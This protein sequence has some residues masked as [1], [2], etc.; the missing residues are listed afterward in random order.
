MYINYRKNYR[1]GISRWAFLFFACC[2]LISCN[3]K[4][5]LKDNQSFL[6][7]NKIT[8]KSKSKI[9]DK[10]DLT[11]NLSHLYRQNQTKTVVGIPRH[12]FYY[13]YQESLLKNPGRKQWSEERLIKNRPVI[14]DSTK[15]AQTVVDFEKYLTL[16]G[17]RYARASFK[18]KTQDK[19][20]SVYYRVDPGPRTYVD[21]F[22]I[23]STD[24]ALIRL[25]QNNQKNS[26][27]TRGSPLDI[28]LYN[29][30]RSRL[31][32]LFQN[33]GY[34]TFDETS[35]SPLEADTNAIR[36]KATLRV[37]N[38]TDSTFHQKYYVGKVT[39]F[40]DYHLTDTI[41]HDTVIRNVKY[42]T[43]HKTLTLKPEVMERNIYVKQGDLTRKINLTQTSRNLGKIELLRFVTPTTEIDTIS[44]DTP[45]VNY[46][47]FLSR[48]K[49][50]PLLLSTELTY[51]NIAGQK[52]S[53]LGASFSANYRDLNTF[54]GAEVLNLNFETGVEFY[55]QA[56]VLN[57]KRDIINSFNINPGASIS[58]PKF[59]DPLHLYHII[60]RPRAD[61][62]PALTG[63][64]LRHWLLYDATTRVNLS[65]TFTKIVNL[66]RYNSFNA[67]LNYDI[68]PDNS[69]KLTIER[70][71]V[72]LFSPIP[73]DSF[74]IRVLNKSKFQLE[75][76]SKQLYTGILFRGY[77][78]DF[79][80]GQKKS[81][82]HIRLLH[83]A[84]ISGAEVLAI[85][86]LTNALTGKKTGYYFGKSNNLPDDTITFSH[87]FKA[88]ID[89][90]YF[91]NFNS[92]RQFGLRI[93]AGFAQ[94]FGFTTQ[95]PYLKQF[96]VGG[97]Q[98]NRAWQVRELGPGGY[99]DTLQTRHPESISSFYQTG[100]IKLDM[101]AELRFHLLWY[102][103]GAIFMDAAN[104]WTA[105]NDTSRPETQFKLKSFLTQLGIGY[106]Y[107]L[108]LDLNYFII[109]FDFGYK[110]YNP[111][112][113][114]GSH[115]LRDEL[116]K[117]PGG[118]ELQIA[119]GMNFD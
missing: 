31:V 39:V 102:L 23:I 106:G 70:F 103:N 93:N 101:S 73:D 91:Y 51:S 49:K 46:T 53:L 55:P 19:E 90:R 47:F 4:K 99:E 88:E 58:F 63:N 111:Y 76:F 2:A 15:A 41:L 115:L 24:T 12:V 38:A 27:F 67:G 116:K 114:N 80:L 89:F 5:Y 32:S 79:N 40:P 66:Y 56:S 35:I 13:H 17:Y 98:S 30:E 7:D 57:G 54:K 20:T 81:G 107:G 117:F 62:Q 87:F 26:F 119:V 25:I 64:K 61:N 45:K 43:P 113:I 108:R 1:P 112:K 18:A 37:L 21:S 104:V 6:K 42:I 28:Q 94:P 109:R 82:G 105:K 48:Y 96:W 3:S 65:Y 14:H 97:A 110:L 100:D 10:A 95:V 72:D 11:E 77:Y 92:Q 69:H 36:V 22:F 75:S 86:Y 85:N 83:N 34:A 9:D 118:A 50:I 8:I 71:G 29:K 84:E 44:S 68:I 16:R 52:R 59:M 78:Y 60:G 74:Q 33:N